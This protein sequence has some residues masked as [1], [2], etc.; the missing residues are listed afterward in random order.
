MSAASEARAGK[1]LRVL[2]IDGGGMRGIVPAT[3]LEHLEALSGRRIADLFDV[4][5]GTSTG[6]IL[7]IGLNVPAADGRPKYSATDFVNM[8]KDLGATIFHEDRKLLKILDGVTRPTYDPAGYEK[9]LHDYFGDATM[10][11]MIV[12][13]AVP[14]IELEDM[15]MHVFSRARGRKGAGSNFLVRE[16]IRAATAAPTYFPAATVSSLDQRSSGTFVDAGVS[17]NNPGIL[18]FAESVE[19]RNSESCIFVSLGTGALTKPI[20]A[21]KARNWGEVEWLKVIFD[22][23]GDA[24]ASYTETTIQEML[25]DKARSYYHRFQVD[26][27]QL[28]FSMDDTKPEHLEELR[29]AAKT[30]VANNDAQIHELVKLLLD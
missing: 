15:Y 1:P 8:Y 22:L 16:V 27:H 23:Q 11:D 24:Q 12:E 14:S 17:T 19:V 9:V 7:A 13:V 4:A 30:Y 21:M 20:N 3:F 2:S 28:P 5:V 6:S 10:A 25:R 18:A 29:N 26:L